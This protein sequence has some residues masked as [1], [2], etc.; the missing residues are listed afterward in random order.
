MGEIFPEKPMGQPAH[1]VVRVL[2]AAPELAA[3]MAET[4]KVQ[5]GYQ[6]LCCEFGASPQSGWSARLGTGRL[7]WH[8]G[9]AGLPP[10]QPV[11]VSD[12]PDPLM[13]ALADL[14]RVTEEREQ[15]R[16]ERDRLRGDLDGRNEHIDALRAELA[17]LEDRR[18]CTAADRGH[19]RDSLRDLSQQLSDLRDIAADKGLSQ[20]AR[21][22]AIVACLEPKE[23]TS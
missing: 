17:E 19:L 22:Q 8:R 3:A 23:P 5:I 6:Q 12:R 7:N 15:F 13:R 20:T 4:R 1:P 10:V 11:P 2:P 14:D 16:K 18:S 21:L 9:N